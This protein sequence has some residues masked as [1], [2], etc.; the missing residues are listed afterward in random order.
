MECNALS[1][2][3]PHGISQDMGSFRVAMHHELVEYYTKHPL[4]F[5]RKWATTARERHFTQAHSTR[6]KKASKERERERERE[7]AQRQ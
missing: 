5:M 4:P 6:R 3:F 7:R 1:R 2:V